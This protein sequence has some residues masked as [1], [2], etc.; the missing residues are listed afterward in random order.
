MIFLLTPIAVRP[1]RPARRQWSQIGLRIGM[2]ALPHP[3]PL[4]LKSARCIVNGSTW[5][6]KL[7]AGSSTGQIHRS[8]EIFPEEI[9]GVRA[10]RFTTTRDTSRSRSCLGQDLCRSA[11]NSQSIKG[12]RLGVPGYLKG[13]GTL[14]FL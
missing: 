10:F 4:K 11:V 6:R 12:T 9:S 8:A 14:H 2:P 3:G 13:F 1:V 7:V 5:F